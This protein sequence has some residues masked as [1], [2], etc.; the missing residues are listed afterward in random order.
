MKTFI[1]YCKANLKLNFEPNIL[2][3]SLVDLFYKSLLV[4]LNDEYVRTARPIM[5]PVTLNTDQLS[6][7]TIKVLG[8]KSLKFT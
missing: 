7:R 3:I 8:E 6:T 4:R 5:I 2:I 1:P